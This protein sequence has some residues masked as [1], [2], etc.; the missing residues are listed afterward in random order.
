MRRKQKTDEEKT[1]EKMAVMLSD[2]RLDLDEVGIAIAR[3]KPATIYN[4]LIV[5]TDSAEEEME[6]QSGRNTTRA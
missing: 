5:L 2:I 4:R 1:A 3:M 6:N